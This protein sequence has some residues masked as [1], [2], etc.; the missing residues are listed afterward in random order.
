CTLGC[1]RFS[2]SSPENE[3]RPIKVPEG[4][5]SAAE[6][7]QSIS[8]AALTERLKK[9][10]IVNRVRLVEVYSR[11][12]SLPRHILFDVRKGSVYEL[13]GLRER[14]VI[15]AVDDFLVYSPTQ[16]VRYLDLM[17]GLP[18]SKFLLEREGVPIVLKFT[19]VE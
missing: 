6:T 7:T 11:D 9:G 2:G 3:T 12:S 1:S 10:P 13:L 8:R 15:I 18:E 16:F 5:V 17:P 19:M 14:D 4:S